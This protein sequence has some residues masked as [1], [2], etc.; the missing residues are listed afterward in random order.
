VRRS[1]AAGGGPE[2]GAVDDDVDRRISR[3]AGGGSALP[4]E[5]RGSM[6]SAFDTDFSGVRLHTGAESAALNQ[7]LQANAFTTGSDIFLGAGTDVSSPA[8]TR[9]LAHELTHVVQQQ[10]GIARSAVIRR[11]DDDGW[12]TVTTKK[13]G[14]NAG[15]GQ[16]NTR[17]GGSG[18]Q[19]HAGG[20]QRNA[21]GGGQRAAAPPA[22]AAAQPAAAA[23]AA[24]AGDDVY[25]TYSGHWNSSRDGEHAT[26][27]AK[28]L[29]AIEKD[30]SIRTKLYKKHGNGKIEKLISSF[31]TTSG[32]KDT[33]RYLVVVT[34]FY[35]KGE[36]VFDT[37][38]TAKEPAAKGDSGTYYQPEFAKIP[39]D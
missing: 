2:G 9:L 21:G 3:M 11:D 6:E 14:G 8:G 25:P 38:Y 22:A 4:A 5:V 20:G 35:N 19:Q 15:G 34:K 12:T 1:V 17:G 10:G 16:R 18:G 39:V 30:P 13:R 29:A 7:Q 37:A 33:G 31:K 23:A 24:P 36:L 27:K 26:G 32:G 28:L